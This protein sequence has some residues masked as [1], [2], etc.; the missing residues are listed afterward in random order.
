MSTG[1][2]LLKSKLQL[3]WINLLD[4]GSAW[5]STLST[6]SPSWLKRFF[7]HEK[8][9][10]ILRPTTEGLELV[11]A[12]GFRPLEPGSKETARLSKSHHIEVALR[13]DQVFQ[14]QRWLP[15]ASSRR[16][17]STLDL[18]FQSNAPFSANE[19]ISD[20]H[21]VEIAPTTKRGLIKHGV[22]KVET[23]KDA[24]EKCR[25][26]GIIPNRV[27]IFDTDTDS[28]H[29][30][31]LPR[32]AFGHF[33]KKANWTNIGMMGLIMAFGVFSTTAYLNQLTGHEEDMQVR[34]A[35]SKAR[36]LPV[37]QQQEEAISLIEED[38][39]LRER[40][41]DR[42]R[43]LNVYEELT[44]SLPQGTQ[45]ESLNYNPGLVRITG[46]TDNSDTIIGD[47][48]AAQLVERA[49]FT[50]PLRR[51]TQHNR[52]HFQ[53]EVSLSN[54][55]EPIKLTELAGR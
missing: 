27:G 26:V 42:R 37:L 18:D 39:F 16:W 7:V 5:I 44:L 45:L 2:N 43:F 46:Y 22:C 25:E 21:L 28:L 51:N 54:T 55:S 19:V 29:F 17:R 6:T 34:V 15:L 10:A 32:S 41:S 31:F 36:A 4:L 35:A 24:L 23:V 11:E 38:K 48:E 3:V 12:G 53:I 9:T 13:P 47:L 1:P 40:F 8:P 30:N 52:D 33:S 20:V 14:R 50:A 49:A